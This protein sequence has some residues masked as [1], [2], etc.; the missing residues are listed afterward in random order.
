MLK[1][2]RRSKRNIDVGLDTGKLG[3]KKVSGIRQKQEIKLKAQS[4]KKKLKLRKKL[5][6]ILR[7]TPNCFGNMLSPKGKLTL[8]YQN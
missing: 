7:A 6:K 1:P 5:Q 3:T 2:Y 4:G 8:V